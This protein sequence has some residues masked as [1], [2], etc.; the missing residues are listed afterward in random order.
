MEL[1]TDCGTIT[2]Q[3]L[4]KDARMLPAGGAVELELERQLQDFG[5]KQTGL[6]QYAIAKYAEALEV[7]CMCNSNSVTTWFTACLPRGVIEQATT[8]KPH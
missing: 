4:C 2:L 1:Y 8:E 6:D 5:R 7:S 3:A